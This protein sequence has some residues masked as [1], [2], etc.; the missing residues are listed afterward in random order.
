MVIFLLPRFSSLQYMFDLH[1]NS[2]AVKKR[3]THAKKRRHEKNCEI[4]GGDPEVVVMV[5]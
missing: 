4:Q 5:G 2:Q 1:E 3:T